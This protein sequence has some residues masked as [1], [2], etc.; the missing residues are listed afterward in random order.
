[1]KKQGKGEVG[2]GE[3]SVSASASL[4]LLLI[5][6]HMVGTSVIK[7][8]GVLDLGGG[9]L[10]ETFRGTQDLCLSPSLSLSLSAEHPMPVSL[11]SVL[12]LFPPA[13]H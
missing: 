12:S 4:F 7:R 10:R 13:M 9:G 6:S 2:E 1:M 5:L 8:H 3:G 11:I